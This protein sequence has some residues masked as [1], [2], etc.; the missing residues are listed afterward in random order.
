M[1]G[2][3]TYQKESDQLADGSNKRPSN[4]GAR[5]ASHTNKG[6][7]KSMSASLFLTQ[8]DFDGPWIEHHKT[9]DDWADTRNIQY[10]ADIIEE[11]PNPI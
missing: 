11:H 8:E 6:P 4:E 5:D 1:A 3:P 9:T 7:S 2:K 10:T